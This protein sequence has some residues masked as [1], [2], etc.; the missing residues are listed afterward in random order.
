MRTTQEILERI[1]EV[2]KDD[3]FGA[4]RSDLMDFLPFAEAK[5]FLKG[6]V[7]E[8]QW[9]QKE[10]TRDS[11]IK[12]IV[13][14]LPFAWDKANNC[15]GLSAGRSID[16]MSAYAWLLGDEELRGLEEVEYEHYGKEKLEYMCKV[17]GVDPKQWDDGVRTNT[18]D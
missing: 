7:T 14:Y 13:D 3:F 11:I 15:R 2:E 6:G 1:K 4:I 17:A 8:D 9:N 5:Q 10:N 18:E 12:E 16:H